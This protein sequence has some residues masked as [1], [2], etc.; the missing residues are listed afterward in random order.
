MTRDRPPTTLPSKV[1]T[2]NCKAYI[3]H[4]MDPVTIRKNILFDPA[5]ILKQAKVEYAKLE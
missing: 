5:M 4:V 3:F 1:G 2:K